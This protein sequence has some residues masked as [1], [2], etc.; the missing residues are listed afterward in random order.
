V[1]DID[2]KLHSVNI[3]LPGAEE[4]NGANGTNGTNGANGK[5]SETKEAYG[6]EKQNPGL[7]AVAKAAA[8]EVTN[9]IKGLAVSN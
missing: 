8:I 1:K 3:D 4:A 6:E 5:N 7:L 2:K 9:G